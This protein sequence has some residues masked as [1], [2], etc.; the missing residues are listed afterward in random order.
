MP[1]RKWG[2]YVLARIF[3]SPCKKVIAMKMKK[4]L[5]LA[6]GVIALYAAAKEYGIN[7]L[8][9]LRRVMSPYLKMLDLKELTQEEA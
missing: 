8:D 9:D 7:S 1:G 5:L 3:L 6:V 2:R 4:E